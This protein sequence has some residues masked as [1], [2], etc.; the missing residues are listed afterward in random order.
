MED[1]ADQSARGIKVFCEQRY[2]KTEQIEQITTVT[3]T[4]RYA[5]IV[6]RDT[7]LTHFAKHLFHHARHRYGIVEDLSKHTREGEAQEEL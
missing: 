5:H 4:S 6:T 1:L 3:V 2:A 7:E